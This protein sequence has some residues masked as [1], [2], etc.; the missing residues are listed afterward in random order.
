MALILGTLFVGITVLASALGILPAESE[1]V[2]S[3]IARRPFGT[4]CSIT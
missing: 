2:V 3:Q 4:G 1:T